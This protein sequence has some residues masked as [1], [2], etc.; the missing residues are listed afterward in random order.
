MQALLVVD[1]QNDFLPGGALPVPYG[2]E[3]VAVINRLMPR[4][5]L[6]VA[7]QDWHPVHHCS[8]L[9]WPPHCVQGSFGAELAAGLRRDLIGHVV[10]KGSDPMREAYSAFAGTRLEEYLR[11][12]GVDLLVVVGLA[13]DF[14]VQETAIEAL[15][16]GFRVR[17]VREGCRAIGD[18]EAAFREMARVGAEVFDIQTLFG[19]NRSPL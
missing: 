8:F 6:V 12:R 7:S 2:D 10:R 5:P 4:F 18:G 19:D 9:Q 16:L 17:V 15:R 13:T 11:T 3:V 14:C 1:V